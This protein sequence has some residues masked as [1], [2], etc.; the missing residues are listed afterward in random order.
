MLF[1]ML[2]LVNCTLT[3]KTELK[4]LMALMHLPE[5]IWRD[6][7]QPGIPDISSYSED[8]EGPSQPHLVEIT[9]VT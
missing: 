9:Y 8:Q 3:G 1:F 6:V 5:T 7:E 2:S 4:L